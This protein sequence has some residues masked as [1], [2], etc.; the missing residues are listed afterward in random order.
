MISNCK[1]YRTNKR[2]SIFPV[3]AAKKY[4]GDTITKLP[5][6]ALFIYLCVLVAGQD[7]GWTKMCDKI[8][9]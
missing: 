2:I 3:V 6:S 5:G 8:L 1:L 9:L 4:G 7:P